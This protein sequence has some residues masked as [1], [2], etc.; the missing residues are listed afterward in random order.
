[1]WFLRLT[2]MLLAVNCNN[3]DK[4]TWKLTVFL[5]FY[6]NY[7][8]SST[9]SIKSSDHSKLLKSILC[10]L[11]KKSCSPNLQEWKCITTL[12][13]KRLVLYDLVS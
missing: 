6:S 8:T 4:N 7:Q 12:V 10:V 2:P 1:M 9:H 3:T 13:L 11:L 5:G